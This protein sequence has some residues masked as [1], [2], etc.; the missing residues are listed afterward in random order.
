MIA[1]SVVDTNNEKASENKKFSRFNI[2]VYIAIL[3]FLIA[4]ALLLIYPGYPSL[5]FYFI[6]SIPI[7]VIFI[8]YYIKRKKESV[9]SPKE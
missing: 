6:T 5:I 8:H 9:Y 2:G 4:L 7:V 1:M 3:L